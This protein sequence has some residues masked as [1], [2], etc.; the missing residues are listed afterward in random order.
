MFYTPYEY[1]LGTIAIGVA[2]LMAFFTW[3]LLWVLPDLIR[4]AASAS[5]SATKAL[6]FIPL[7]V[8]RTMGNRKKKRRNTRKKVR[9]PA[10]SLYR[11]VSP[12]LVESTP[13]FYRRHQKAQ[14][15]EVGLV[16]SVSKDARRI[17]D[18]V[19]DKTRED[20]VD[21]AIADAFE[22][23]RKDRDLH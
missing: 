17:A 7:H 16:R 13:A 1:L 2:F 6:F 12:L 15:T 20:A 3:R 23:A 22:K 21:T 14:Q 5:V 4:S 19:V 18:K 10:F 9:Q 11:P 8:V